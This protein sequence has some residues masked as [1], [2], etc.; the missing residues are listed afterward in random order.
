MLL[1]SLCLQG[2]L[3]YEV[4]EDEGRLQPPSHAMP[5][6]HVMLHVTC[7]LAIN[8][9]PLVIRGSSKT[10]LVSLVPYATYPDIVATP[11]N[12]SHNYVI[13]FISFESA[14]FCSSVSMSVH[15]WY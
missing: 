15:H 4:G 7:R 5:A 1:P 9:S 12:N 3:I 14:P 13:P 11:L 2:N 8:L 6:R 10:C